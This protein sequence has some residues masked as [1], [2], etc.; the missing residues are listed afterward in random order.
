MG[1]GVSIFQPSK[2]Y[3]LRPLDVNEVAK[4]LRV[5]ELG[6]E[7][8]KKELPNEGQTTLDHNEVAIGDQLKSHRAALTK[9]VSIEL[10]VINNEISAHRASL[11]SEA[12]L[13]N[14]RNTFSELKFEAQSLLKKY[15]RECENFS[16]TEANYQAYVEKRDIKTVPLKQSHWVDD[17]AF[18]G[19]LI[20]SEAAAN[21]FFF[22]EGN[23]F[24][25]LGAMGIA[26]AIAAVNILGCYGLGILFKSINSV[27]WPRKFLGGLVLI[28]LT[29]LLIVLH[30][31]AAFYR[32]VRVE[33]LE[34]SHD[35][36]LRTAF[37]MMFELR[38]QELGVLSIV[39]F[40]MGIVF[41]LMSF[42]KGFRRGHPYPGFE[43]EFF[44]LET[45]R[46]EVLEV[47][48]DLKHEY[49]DKLDDV[50]DELAKSLSDVPQRLEL[51]ERRTD[52]KRD[53]YRRLKELPQELADMANA[54]VTM[55]R[56]ENEAVRKSAAPA[57]FSD[58]GFSRDD[59][60]FS[61]EFVA[62]ADPGSSASPAGMQE[63]INTKC[64]ALIDELEA[65]G[66]T[67]RSEISEKSPS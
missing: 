55:Y 5:R 37:M 65:F 31:I 51:I 38:F 61:Q 39:L 64:R 35:E 34:A 41:G 63:D 32:G 1:D 62:S 52:K 8:G 36:Q 42:W 28:V 10:E 53:I 14:A 12:T 49:L 2:A 4:Q 30:G 7:T 33:M 45:A 21:L 66:A 23:E 46:D 29:G 24:G 18:F 3:D 58:A 9:E 59:F 15:Q 48:E 22:Q 11:L 44:K 60:E 47:E 27:F 25:I 6:K 16:K 26:T 67:L 19:G 54:L 13:Q 50:T 43:K 20:V 56:K 17:L 40:M 57:Y